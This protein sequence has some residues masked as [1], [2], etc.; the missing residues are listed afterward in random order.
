MSLPDHP[1][2]VG[3]QADRLARRLVREFSVLQGHLPAT[4]WLN[5]ED[6]VAAEVVVH[7]HHDAETLELLGLDE[8]PIFML[9]VPA[10][11]TA[12]AVTA[13]GEH[14][15][16]LDLGDGDQLHVAAIYHAGRRVRTITAGP[17]IGHG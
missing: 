7:T 11:R 10:R 8:G 13:D 1:N 14:A 3:A 16:E 9:G 6:D 2:R 5:V 17:Q 12:F 4:H 15:V